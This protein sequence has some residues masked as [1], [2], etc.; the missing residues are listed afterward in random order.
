MK[1]KQTIGV[2]QLVEHILRSGDLE[3]DF[4]GSHHADKGIRAHQKIQKS[5]P[6]YYLPEVPVSH[7]V[8]TESMELIIR[9][10]IDGLF[11][12]TEPVT[13][14]EIK[15]T[16]RPLDQI[17]STENPLH[18]GQLKTYGYLYAIEN[19][20]DEI[21][22]RLTYHQVETGEVKELQN[23]FSTSNL[24]LFFQDLIY[25]YLKWADA[26]LKL[27]KIRDES[28]RRLEFPFKTYRP[29]QRRMAEAV[30]R[31]IKSD[32]QLIIQAATGIG[33]TIAAIFP[34]F[35]A[36]LAGF[37]EKIFY[38]TAKNTGKAATEKALGMLREKGLTVK[39]ITLTAKDRICFRPQSACSGKECEYAKGFYDRLSWGLEEIFR[40]DDFTR[41]TV[42]RYSEKYRLCPFEYSLELALWTDCII[43][44]YNYA[45]DPLV[46]L[47]QFFQN[48]TKRYAFMIDEAHNLVERSREMYSSE[49]RKQALLDTR[50]LLRRDLPTVY[51]D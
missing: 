3:H 20:L 16:T 28:I 15:T 43:C 30:Y 21:K 33:K 46:S 25:R 14:E 9:G 10:R 41:R 31:A 40:Q 18:W 51:R 11:P 49:I 19:R 17:S 42:E 22:L 29:G 26:I 38:L 8:E 7:M 35:K 32:R 37:T 45:F 6:G 1:T 2:N 5:R 47:K 48:N 23:T 44:D 39:S 12:D 34:A 27:N 4:I 24:K 50:R 36:M 13:I